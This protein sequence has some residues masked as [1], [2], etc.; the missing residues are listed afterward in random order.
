MH[1]NLIVQSTTSTRKFPN[2]IGTTWRAG[3]A[4]YLFYLGRF[5]T[6]IADL[7]GLIGRQPPGVPLDVNAGV[8]SG[9][10]LRLPCPSSVSATSSSR[11]RFPKVPRVTPGPL[12]GPRFYY[13]NPQ[14]LTWKKRERDLINLYTVK[15]GV[16]RQKDIHS[17]NLAAKLPNELMKADEYWIGGDGISK[18]GRK[19]KGGKRR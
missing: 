9:L 2:R 13:A 7:D 16:R 5:W 14:F 11:D 10:L 17:A 3:W 12:L 15:Y 4:I 6:G 18:D 1:L 8:H 19:V